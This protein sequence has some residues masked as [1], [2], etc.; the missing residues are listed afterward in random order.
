M[1]DEY[2]AKLQALLAL[3][4]KIITNDR[5]KRPGFPGDYKTPEQKIPKLRQDT[6]G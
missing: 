4:P 1:T 2:A 5:L 3:Q 6:A